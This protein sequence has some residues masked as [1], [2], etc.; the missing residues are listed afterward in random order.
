MITRAKRGRFGARRGL[1]KLL[2]FALAERKISFA[3]R[4]YVEFTGRLTFIE[5]RD[6]LI[7]R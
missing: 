5:N 6:N 7:E 1:F 3:G 2:F 4:D